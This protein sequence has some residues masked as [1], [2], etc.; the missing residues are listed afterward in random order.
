MPTRS[1]A[2]ATAPDPDGYDVAAIEDVY[3]LNFVNDPRYGGMRVRVREPSAGQ[4]E[5]MLDLGE[6]AKAGEINKATAKDLF[7][8]LASGL[9]DWNLRR[10]G[11]AIPAD[12][13][14]VRTMGLPFLVQMLDAWTSAHEAAVKAAAEGITGQPLE[15]TSLPM[16]GPP[17]D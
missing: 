12:A 17:V 15:I 1:K 16:E 14:G 10:D 6:R 7:D 8:L 4:L 5:Q 9:K 11:V 3:V 2:K 13:D